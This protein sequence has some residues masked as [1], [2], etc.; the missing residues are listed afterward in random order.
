MFEEKKSVK[1]IWGS[2]HIFHQKYLSELTEKID[3]NKSI[4]PQ[5]I[6]P[7]CRKILF[8]DI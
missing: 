3:I 8:N 7:T 6:C 1:I 2:F 4:L 5:F